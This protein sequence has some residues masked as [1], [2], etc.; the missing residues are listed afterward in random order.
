MSERTGSVKRSMQVGVCAI[1]ADDTVQ[2]WGLRGKTMDKPMFRATRYVKHA[3]GAYH[4]LRSKPMTLQCWGVCYNG[5]P[6]P[7]DSVGQKHQYWSLPH[8]QSKLW[9]VMWGS[10]DNA[11]DVPLNCSKL[12]KPRL[13]E[14]GAFLLSRTLKKSQ[15]IPDHYLL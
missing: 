4:T 2:C 11:L 5:Q 3:A 15:L 12:S 1:K 14:F 9:H 13:H 10:G 6:V 8:Q 7:S